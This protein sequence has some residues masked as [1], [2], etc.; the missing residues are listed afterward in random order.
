MHAWIGFFFSCAMMVVAAL[1]KSGYSILPTGIGGTPNTEFLFLMGCAGFGAALAMLAPSHSSARLASLW[2]A[3]ALAAIVVALNMTG[4]S[5]DTV[6]QIEPDVAVEVPAKED[7]T[8]EEA[9]RLPVHFE[10][11]RTVVNKDWAPFEDFDYRIRQIERDMP[12]QPANS[13]ANPANIP[14]R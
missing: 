3:G 11:K 12:P 14:S 5:R 6:K 7:A 1:G 2:S 13:E 9:D 8:V 10:L 4:F